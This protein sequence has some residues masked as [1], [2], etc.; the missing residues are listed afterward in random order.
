MARRLLGVAAAASAI[1]VTAATSYTGTLPYTYSVAWSLPPTS[2]LS[3]S[4][5]LPDV[6]S[7][8]QGFMRSSRAVYAVS[9]LALM[10]Y[11]MLNFEVLSRGLGFRFY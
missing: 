11:S 1:S 2:R 9:A 3:G 5:P 6:F 7:A 4:G 10:E 8:G